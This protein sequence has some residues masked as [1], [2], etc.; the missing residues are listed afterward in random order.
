VLTSFSSSSMM[1]GAWEGVMMLEARNLDDHEEA[2]RMK[3]GGHN[4]MN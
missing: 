1:S 3:V 4:I 2:R